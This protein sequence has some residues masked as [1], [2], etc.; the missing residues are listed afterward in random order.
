MAITAIITDI[1]AME[2]VMED[3]DWHWEWDCWVMV[4]ATTAIGHPLIPPPMA[5]HR[6]VMRQAMDTR[7]L[8]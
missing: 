6:L 4:S 2:G 8:L 3:T 1:T 5:I 7:L